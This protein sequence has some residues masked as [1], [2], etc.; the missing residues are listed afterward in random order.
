MPED[1]CR[2]LLPELEAWTHKNRRKHPRNPCSIP[3]DYATKDQAFKGFI[4]NVSSGGV[5]IHT[6]GGLKVGEK[7]TMTFSS[8]DQ[9]DP[10]KITG[11]I[12]RKNMLGVGIRFTKVIQDFEKSTWIDCRSKVVEVSEERRIDPRVEFRCPV[13][14]EGFQGGQFAFREKF[15]V[16]Q[17]IC[18]VVKLPTEDETIRAQ[19]RIMGFGSRG[20]HCKFIHLGRRSQEAIEYCFNVAKHTLPIR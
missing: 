12:V 7:M 3:V 13:E 11:E 19:A 18:L 17:S 8:P 6:N 16:D 10:V 1:Q 9:Q 5:F 4:K 14:I 15:R 2:T 20:L